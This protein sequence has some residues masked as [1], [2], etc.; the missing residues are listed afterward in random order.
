[1]R[2]I[3]QGEFVRHYLTGFEYVVT[4]LLPCRL[5]RVADA[6]NERVYPVVELSACAPWPEREG[7][8]RA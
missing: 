5:A 7:V 4:E 6:D 1:V 3:E 2:R 8:S